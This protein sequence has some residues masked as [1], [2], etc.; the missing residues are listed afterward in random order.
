MV[1]TTGYAVRQRPA[2]LFKQQL[3]DINV[4][5]A[6]SVFHPKTALKDIASVD[7]KTSYQVHRVGNVL[8]IVAGDDIKIRSL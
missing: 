6:P 8:C 5:M 4:E 7:P 2:S 3:C 1:G